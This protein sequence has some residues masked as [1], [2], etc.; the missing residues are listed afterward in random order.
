MAVAGSGSTLKCS[1]CSN[2]FPLS[3]R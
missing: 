3:L 2:Q 1:Y